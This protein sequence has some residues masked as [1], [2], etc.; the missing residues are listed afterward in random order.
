[1]KL[2]FTF[3]SIV[4]AFLATAQ[5]SGDFD[6]SNWTLVQNT[7]NGNAYVDASGAPGSIVFTGSDSN[8]P[9]FFA[10]YDDYQ[11]TLPNGFSGCLSF[12][13]S[14]QNLDVDFLDAF[15]YVV[16][17]QMTFVSYGTDASASGTITLSLNA[18]DVFGFRIYNGDNIY[19]PGVLTVSNIFTS[20]PSTNTTIEVA[21]DSYT[22]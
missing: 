9:Q 2:I 21:C 19:G 14:Y 6:P 16:N 20:T 15:Q 8:E 18:G 22:W 3:F 12:D 7:Q 11:I 10:G 13:Y 17:G 4:C 1:M 5:F